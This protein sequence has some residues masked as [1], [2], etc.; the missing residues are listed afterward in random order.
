MLKK[1]V[2]WAKEWWASLTTTIEEGEEIV[3]V[4]VEPTPVPDWVE[5]LILLKEI[6][7]AYQYVERVELE[8]QMAKARHEEKVRSWRENNRMLD[9][10]YAKRNIQQKRSELR[11]V[12]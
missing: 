1:V 6:E 12:A 11:L 9:E 8:E 7:R 3:T 5:E 10:M 2:R 4:E